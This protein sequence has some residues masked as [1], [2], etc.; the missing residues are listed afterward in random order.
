MAKQKQNV[1]AV[2]TARLADHDYCN[3]LGPTS[4]EGDQPQD[5]TPPSSAS[6]TEL[7]SK[8]SSDI[9]DHNYCRQLAPNP[10]GTTQDSSSEQ[11]RGIA[12]NAVSDGPCNL[13]SQELFSQGDDDRVENELLA[14]DPPVSLPVI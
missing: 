1:A 7:R 6:D 5:L 9:Q 11:V 10:P 8:L 14:D 3:V 13:A 2:S 12:Q 4:L